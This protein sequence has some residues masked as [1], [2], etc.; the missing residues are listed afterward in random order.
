M[1]RLLALFAAL[2]LSW[3]AAAAPPTLEFDVLR[4]GAPIGKHRVTIERD[5]TETRA[6]IEI[7]MAVR[8]AFVTVYR[9][10]HRSTELWREGRLVSLD[11][12]T[13]DNGTRTQ[14]S[15]RATDAGLAIDG[16]G[17]RYD[18]PAE[19]VPTSYWNREKVMRSPLLDTQSG[20]LI[21]VSAMALAADANGTRYRLA[22][23]LEA[24]L[25]YGPGGDWTGLSFSARGARIDYV[26]RDMAASAAR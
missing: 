5:G 16:S 19:T 8:L 22:G 17:G 25:V 2:V 3:P 24:D 7:D 23:D 26:R 9:Y 1:S 11:A 20:K 13:D 14:V 4:D 10:T 18:A 12:R 21:D 15:A 6:T